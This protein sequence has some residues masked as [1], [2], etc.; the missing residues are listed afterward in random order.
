MKVRP[1]RLKRGDTVAIVALSSGLNQE[2]L[3]E[4]LRFLEMLGL[5]YKI[6]KT[7]YMPE[8]MLAGTDEERLFDLH[9]FVKDPE[10]KAIICARG[11]YGIA[12]L[13]DKIDYTLIEEN[14]KIFLGFSDVTVLHTVLNEYSNLV[15]FHGPML[16]NIE[17]P[18]DDLSKKMFQQ[19]FTPIEIQYT[20]DI[21]TLQTIVPGEVRGELTGGNLNRFVGTLGTKFEIDVRGKIL[22]IEDI[23]ESVMRIDN[24]LNQL[25]LARK[26]EQAAGFVIGDF[27][28]L[29]ENECYEDVI[30]IFESYIGHLNKPAVAGFKIGHCEPNIMIPLGVDAILDANE[31]VLKILPGVE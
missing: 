12:R 5:Q 18:L 20:E 11:G 24:M 13:I 28:K 1:N 22:V 19:L 27:S 30:R 25:R 17:K 16:S 15:T 6:G 21:S 31:K 26:L 23:H 7:V 29:G 9:H 10:V 4:K 3:I 2:H 14:P 8:G